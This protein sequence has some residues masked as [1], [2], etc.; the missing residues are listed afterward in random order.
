MRRLKSRMLLGLMLPTL[1]NSAVGAQALSGRVVRA[2]VG[3][4]GAIVLLLDGQRATQ[5]RALTRDGGRFTVAAPEA[6]SYTV[7]VLRIGYAPTVAGPFLLRAGATP[8]ADVELTGDAVVLDRMTVT[9]R[10]ECRVHPDSAAAAFHIWE[11]ARKALLATSLTRAEPL[12]MLVSRT[13]RTLDR[14]GERILDQVSSTAAGRSINPFVS[15]PPDSA[16]KYGY[17]TQRADGRTYWGP[18]AEI[19]LS[20]SFAAAHCLRLEQR[21]SSPKLVG[22]AFAPATRQRDLVDIEGVVWVDRA[23]AELR[24]LDYR[25]VNHAIAERARAGGRVDFLRLPSGGWVVERWSIRYP[26]VA[27][28]AGGRD[29]LV[30]PGISRSAQTTEELA[31]VKV[32]SG[33][34]SEVRRGSTLFWERGRISV[35][36]RVV[37]EGSGAPIAGVLVGEASGSAATATGPDGVTRLDRV[38][39]GPL[40]LRVHSP[41]LEAFGEAAV[42][43]PVTATT[44]GELLS[45]RI[46][47]PRQL[48]VARCGVRALEW[49]EGLVRGKLAPASASR[50]HAVVRWRTPYTRLS[51]G[52]PV[53]VEEHREVAT[54]STGRFDLCGVPRDAQV[55]IDAPSAA[56]ADAAPAWRSFTPGRLA[57]VWAT[58]NP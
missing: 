38:A 46:P 30:T 53:L 4:D 3:V 16:A 31:G 50:G 20:A 12:S 8:T 32:S 42:L 9:D 56:S 24:A 36:V 22:V 28:R 26:I 5:G 14:D 58:S 40:T 34:I 11:E 47:T 27:V 49:G 21:T 57:L 55:S 52:E 15:L 54:D 44:D 35:R 33:A 37:D 17:V 10:S 13:E 29:R 43:M 45:L 23:T 51:G 39:P 25:Y 6:G 41:E 7:R 2:G 48:F 19:L 1:L 18:D